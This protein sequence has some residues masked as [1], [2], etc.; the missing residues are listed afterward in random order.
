VTFSG[1]RWGENQ[2]NGSQLS[3]RIRVLGV[4]ALLLFALIFFRLWYLQVLSGDK[5]LAEAQN[6]RV[7]E[8][9]VQAPRGEIRDR[10][11]KVLV[12]NRTALALQVHTDQLPGR[13]SKRD[14]VLAR[15]AGLAQMSPKA[16]HK[17]IRKQTKDVPGS[18]VT[19]KRDVPFDLVYFLRE[20]QERFPGVSVDRV[21]VRQYPQGTLGAHIFGYVRE[22]NAEQLKE[23]QYDDLLPGDEIGQDGVELTYDHLLRGANG[24]SKIK[25]DAAG[26]PTGEAVSEQDP[27]AGD[28][29]TLSI[30]SKL[31]ATGEAQLAATG[32]PGAFVALSPNDGQVLALGSAPTFDPS[33]L[34]KPTISKAT[35]ESIFGSPDD[36]DSTG[37]PAFDRAIAAG[38]P[39][40]STF[41]PITALAA[42]DQG[43][44]T[45]NE[46]I[47]DA[48]FIKVGDQK[49]TNAG[50]E[51]HGPVQLRSALQVSSD[52][53]FYTLGIRLD[54]LVERQKDPINAIQDWAEKLG[55]GAPTGIDLPGEIAGNVPSKSWR[56]DLYTKG[57]TDRPWSVGDS[58]NLSVG[59]GDL[60]AD[61]LQMAVAYSAIA[62]GGTVVT[63]HV[64][65]RAKDPSGDV[66]QEIDPAPQREVSIDPQ[67]RDAIM[68]GLHAA[69]TEPGG[70]SYP[71]FGGF[72]IPV[73]GKTGTAE[74]TYQGVPQNQSWYVAMAPY[75]HPKIVVALTIERGGFGAEAA[76]P[77]VEKMLET[78]FHVKPG[79]VGSTV[80]TDG[81]D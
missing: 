19:L 36:Q 20:N 73:A 47:Q 25:V 24:V 60:Q 45:I 3:R 33:A 43:L 11:G 16:V 66:V 57:L 50:D 51:V 23:P 78:Y 27:K 9:T 12:D 38:Y 63:P 1:G 77:A 46:T 55:L 76:A 35:A 30:D 8:I 44:L 6:N 52:V 56:D 61:P 68:Q 58:I 41:K 81:Y 37:A 42:L 67:W 17:A 5:Y 69:A 54:H 72:P 32:L 15:I 21:Y 4:F 80:V 70:T 10:N 64:G 2:L 74:T 75:D 40:G 7:R 28:D 34:S 65:L 62:N 49:F 39:T 26:Q 13:K 59:Q 71:V 48:G 14:S 79:D 29:L 22:V 18:P 31:Q 53:F